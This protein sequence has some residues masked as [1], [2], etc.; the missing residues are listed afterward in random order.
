MRDMRRLDCVLIPCLWSSIDSARR[1]L[2][3]GGLLVLMIN[4]CTMGSPGHVSP[5]AQADSPGDTSQYD[6]G[7]ADYIRAGDTYCDRS[8]PANAIACYKRALAGTYQQRIQG[9]LLLN[10]GWAYSEL[11]QFA[12]AKA[13][14]EQALVIARQERNSTLEGS[15]RQRL[16]ITY[17]AL[18]Q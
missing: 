10:L 8:Q 1:L 13:S 4:G 12:T 18:G 15:A 14:Y 11:G 3:G 6:P 16:G 17:M 9:R 2:L 5:H 7:R